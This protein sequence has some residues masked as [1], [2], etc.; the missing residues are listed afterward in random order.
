VDVVTKYQLKDG[1]WITKLRPTLD[2]SQPGRK[3]WVD[4]S[5]TQYTTQ[6]LFEA[7][8]F[9][10]QHHIIGGS[11]VD[12][13]SFFTILNR[14]IQDIPSN[15]VF[16]QLPGEEW[17]FHYIHG[18]AFGEKTTPFSADVLA[19]LLQKIQTHHIDKRCE[20]RHFLIRRVDDTMILH[21]D[22]LRV[23]ITT[24][25]RTPKQ[26][27]KVALTIFAAVCA[28]AGVPIQHTKTKRCEMIN[29][30]DGY[31]F[32]WGTNRIGYPSDK[33]SKLIDF[34]DRILKI[35]DQ[36]QHQRAAK[37]NKTS[38]FRNGP[39][40]YKLLQSVVGQLEYAAL[41]WFYYRPLI[42]P[43]RHCYQYLDPKHTP[44]VSPTAYSALTKFRYIASQPQ[45]AWV[46]IQHYFVNHHG[47]SVRLWTD[48]SGEYGIG[49]HTHYE[50]TTRLCFAKLIPQGWKLHDSTIRKGISTTWLELLAL[51]AIL[52]QQGTNWN[53]YTV[54]WYTDSLACNLIVQNTASKIPSVNQLLHLVYLHC[55]K[56][57]IQIAPTWVPREHN[58]LADMLSNI[59]FADFY[60]L[61]QF[62]PEDVVSIHRSTYR[63]AEKTLLD[64]PASQ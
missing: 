24:P 7:M 4:P 58:K 27:A 49:G 50:D 21:S 45:A 29:I 32:C 37:K 2:G 33:A 34:I 1:E 51:Y 52:I 19:S 23:D 63:K 28:R 10:R 41:V 42:L 30:F 13:T 57:T 56:H 44:T 26:D 5:L 8:A 60:L 17:K 20:Y 43:I 61:T 53:N 39:T 36:S 55:S 64:L 18:H 14:N 16:W 62:R 38:V 12:Y 31:A 9:S 47:P 40:L 54:H 15:C 35:A 11:L 3:E 59:N 25:T 48:A 22:T 46:P 6:H